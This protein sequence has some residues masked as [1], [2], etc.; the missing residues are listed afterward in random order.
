MASVRARRSPGSAAARRSARRS[1]ARGCASPL[2]RFAAHRR[3]L[4]PHPRA[5][6]IAAAMSNLERAKQVLKKYGRAGAVTYLGISSMVTTGACA[7]VSVCTLSYS[8]HAA[9]GSRGSNAAAS[10]AAG[11]AALCCKLHDG[12]AAVPHCCIAAAG[13]TRTSGSRDS[14]QPTP[15][16]CSRRQRPS[17]LSSYCHLQL[18][19]TRCLHLSL[20]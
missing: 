16:P 8:T 3:H 7:C 14:A 11:R 20:P 1:G 19:G 15:R 13:P 18:P 2:W 9:C 17:C 12:P 5:Q 4:G 10:H 6:C